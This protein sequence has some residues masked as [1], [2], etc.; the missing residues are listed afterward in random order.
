[1]DAL[2][3][4]NLAACGTHDWSITETPVGFLEFAPN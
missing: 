3:L 2:L 4:K 1:M